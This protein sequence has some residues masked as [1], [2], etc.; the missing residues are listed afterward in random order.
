MG[1]YRQ[2]KNDSFNNSSTVHRK[3]HMEKVRFKTSGAQ[4][5]LAEFC[6]RY[7]KEKKRIQSIR[8]VQLARASAGGN[9]GKEISIPP[10]LYDI[11]S[12][13]TEYNW[14]R[15]K[16][17]PRQETIA[18][19]EQIGFRITKCLYNFNGKKSTTATG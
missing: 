1:H 3:D 19:L 18:A 15:G 8:A 10:G 13:V 2:C 4:V 6:L 17:R 5:P 16:C 14:T 11:I 12:R 7:A 9:E